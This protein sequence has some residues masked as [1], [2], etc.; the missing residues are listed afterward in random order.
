MI[1]CHCHLFESEDVVGEIEEFK[2]AGGTHLI[3]NGAGVE[4]S[5]KALELAEKF[6]E[7]FATA[8]I[9][10]E[11]SS[12]H[13]ILNPKE[14]I[15][16]LSHRKVVA[17]GECGL[18]YYENTTEEEKQWQRELFEFNLNLAKETKLPIVV[19]CR[20]AF[21]DVYGMVK[22]LDIV[23]QMHCYTGNE[24]WMRKFV[25]LGWY[26]SFGGILTFKSSHQLRDVVKMTPQERLLVE[27]DAPY[28]APEPIRGTR[29]KSQNVMI[30]ARLIA[31]LRGQTVEEVDRYTTENAKRLFSKLSHD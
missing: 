7:V 29:N 23:G 11:E 28:L 26:I 14:F 3:C 31:D 17:V 9:H 25:D 16:I 2:M 18:D 13:E 21:E 30:V 27:T 12:K 6:P 1:D 20:N 15:N 4:T 19:H 22:D 10:P 24:K 5:K 8:G